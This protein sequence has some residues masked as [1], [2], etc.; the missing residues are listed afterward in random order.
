[1]FDPKT[2]HFEK[3]KKTY[4]FQKSSFAKI[5]IFVTEKTLCILNVKLIYKSEIFLTI[6]N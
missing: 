2:K 1:M 6:F 5:Y 3:D 4:E